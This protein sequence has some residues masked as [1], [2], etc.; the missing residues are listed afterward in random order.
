M[1]ISP[2]TDGEPPKPTPRDGFGGSAEP[3]PARGFHRTGRRRGARGGRG[4]EGRL[5]GAGPRRPVLGTGP[6][7]PR[8]P[9]AGSAGRRGTSR[10]AAIA[11]DQFQRRGGAQGV[12]AGCRSQGADPPGAQA[13]ETGPMG[14]VVRGR[15]RP[16]ATGSLG[17]PGD[18]A[19]GPT[20]PPGLPQVPSG[21]PQGPSGSRPRPHPAGP[22]H[23]TCPW[24]PEPASYN[25]PPC[26]QPPRNP[27]GAGPRQPAPRAPRAP[28]QPPGPPP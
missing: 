6:V 20:R 21:P 22:P 5:Q 14:G 25:R 12:V 9:V 16:P 4:P 15:G 13:R 3:D 7:G 11:G 28:G 8:P 2:P 24:A 27:L 10:E 18:P 26:A 19:T 23:E 17:S 1:E